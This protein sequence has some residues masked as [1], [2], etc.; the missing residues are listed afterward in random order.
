M[1]VTQQ[2]TKS[3]ISGQPAC[4]VTR[5]LSRCGIGAMALLLAAAVGVTARAEAGGQ[6]RSTGSGVYTDAQASRGATVFNS[7]CAVCHA[8]DLSGNELGPPLAGSGFLAYWKDLS[9]A[10][11]MQVMSISMPQDNPGSLDPS[12]YI[13]LIAFMMQKSD[14]PS[15]SE[16]L[17]EDA[18]G[19]I[20]IKVE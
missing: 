1:L 5:I 2:T 4:R 10:D 8:D 17:T 11:L 3:E 9:L 13:E 12:E 16:E 15:G 14:F 18:L 7:T 6:E 20:M 19:E